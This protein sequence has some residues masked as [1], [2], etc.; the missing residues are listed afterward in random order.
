V[1]STGPSQGVFSV[2]HLRLAGFL[3]S[4]CFTL[5]L[6]YVCTRLYIYLFCRDS[7]R[8][9]ECPFSLHTSPVKG[10]NTS[11]MTLSDLLNLLSFFM[12]PVTKASAMYDLNGDG[13]IS[14][15][16]LIIMLGM[17]G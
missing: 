15:S 5:Y 17:L 2:K 14:T 9:W 12:Q 3:H 13:L 4:L 8:E 7:W 11:M 10:P 16:D 6:D 1:N